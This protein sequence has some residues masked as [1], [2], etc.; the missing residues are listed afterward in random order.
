MNSIEHT[1]GFDEYKF[2]CGI[3]SRTALEM[4]VAH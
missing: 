4:E 1:Y 2:S 3:A